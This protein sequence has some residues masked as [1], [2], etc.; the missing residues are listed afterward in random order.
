[1]LKTGRSCLDGINLSLFPGETF[2]LL[3]P[4]GSGKS[5]LL[6]TIAGKRSEPDLSL[7]STDKSCK[8]A[9]I[10]RE[11][12]LNERPGSDDQKSFSLLS[13]A[14]D[15]AP[16]HRRNH[17]ALNGSEYLR[18]L[19]LRELL[20]KPDILLLDDPCSWAPHGRKSE[21]RYYLNRLREASG[22]TMLIA[23]RD[24]Y[25]AIALGNR[26][27]IL[28]RG[29][30]EQRGNIEELLNRPATSYVARYVGMS[31]LFSARI[32]RV[33]GATYAH[34]FT[35]TSIPVDDPAVPFAP[36]R[37]VVVA[38]RPEDVDLAPHCLNS[39]GLDC[40]EA[41]VE[42]IREKGFYYEIECRVGKGT[43]TAA[44]PS[45]HFQKA[46][47]KRGDRVALSWRPEA[48]RILEQA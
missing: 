46:Q 25:D 34:A 5:A 13:R 39:D 41:L 23:S 31:N 3:G 45:S 24:F 1:M 14:L 11:S 19:L 29:R 35:T 26:A 6:E 37:S 22:I 20:T 17:A 7:N 21:I 4:A 28:N 32:I 9:F 2:L 8:V 43:I 27:A 42:A 47:I 18:M 10:N 30:I 38:L 33:N 16:L 12:T 48:V 44:L 36:E 15:L 40:V